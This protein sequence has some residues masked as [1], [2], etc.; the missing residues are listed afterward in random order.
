MLR[1]SPKSL[2]EEEQGKHEYNL[3]QCYQMNRMIKHFMLAKVMFQQKHFKVKQIHQ[4][5][6]V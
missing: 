6:E 5:K 2:I 4:W 3:Q 1:G